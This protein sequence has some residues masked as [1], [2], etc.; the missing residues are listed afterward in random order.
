MQRLA[1]VDIGS[2]TVH[3]LVCD[4]VKGRLQEIAHEV[5][6]PSLGAAVAK[7]GE[8]GEAKAAE[9]IKDLRSVLREASRHGYQHLV[10]GAT[11]AVRQ[12]RD[13]DSFLAQ[14]S[15]TAGV[16]VRLIDPEREA[17]LSFLGVASVHASPGEWLM[18]DMGGGST[19][20]VTARNCDVLSWISLPVGSGAL[21]SHYLSDPPQPDERERL[22]IDA[23]RTL[24]ARAPTSR[25]ERLV[26]TGGTATNLPLV[27]E[28][29][30]VA[31]KLSRVDLSEA[32]TRLDASA[33]GE[34]AEELGLPAARVIA[35]RAGV[36]VLLLLLDRYDL[37]HLHVSQEGIR[38]GMLLAYL[39]RG[40]DWWR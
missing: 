10:A 3:A 27:L 25:P 15:T 14:A 35:L 36:E 33:A 5:A 1:A 9:A 34:L 17:R 30:P 12:A 22:R 7:T 26:M 18:G 2:N 31:A 21:A 8:I 16:P 38:H 28:R 23:G 11:E 4:I 13:R 32:R 19:E 39:E 40:E 24:A 20:L 6:M 29:R 37:P